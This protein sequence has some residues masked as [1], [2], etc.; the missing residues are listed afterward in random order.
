MPPGFHPC[1]QDFIHFRQYIPLIYAILKT[2]IIGLVSSTVSFP[3]PVIYIGIIIIYRYH[4]SFLCGVPY[5]IGN[6][7]Q[8]VKFQ[9]SAHDQH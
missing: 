6:N 8:A 2:S 3:Y 1:S 7:L 4:D 9:K 5:T